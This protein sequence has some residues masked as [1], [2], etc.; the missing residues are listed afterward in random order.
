M[1]LYTLSTFLVF[2]ITRAS[3][4][5]ST[6]NANKTT[7]LTTMSAVA[8]IGIEFW[9]IF[10]EGSWLFSVPMAPIEMLTKGDWTCCQLTGQR[11]EEEVEGEEEEEEGL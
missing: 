6:T 1:L 8:H 5:T 4:T 10:S 3:W 2:S 9:D 11:K 7:Q